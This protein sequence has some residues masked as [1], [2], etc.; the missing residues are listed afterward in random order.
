MLCTQHRV[1]VAKIIHYLMLLSEADGMEVFR[2]ERNCK[3][4]LDPK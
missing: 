3:L 2:L 4:C 1:L